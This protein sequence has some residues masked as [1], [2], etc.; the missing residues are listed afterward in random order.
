MGALFSRNSRSINEIYDDFKSGTLIIDTGYQRKKIWS[1]QDNVRFIETVLL[2]LVIP[3]VF[4]WIAETEPKTGKTITHIVD[5]QQRINAIVDFIDGQFILNKRFLLS[6]NMRIKHG[7]K[8]FTELGDESKIALWQY[9]FPIVELDRECTR[10]DIKNIFR[11]LNLTEYSL[12]PQ[13]RHHSEEDNCFGIA[14]EKLAENDFW[15]RMRVFSA[16]DCKRMKD[17]TYCCSIYILAKDGIIDQTDSRAVNEH[18]IDY[19]DKFDDD[20]AILNRIYSAMDIVEEFVD[21]DTLQFASK[22]A[23]LFS[24]MSLAFFMVDSRLSVTPANFSSFKLFVKA[25]SLFKNDY[26]ITLKNERQR[27]VYDE[28]RKYKLASSEG[29]NKGTNRT[30]RYKILYDLCIKPNSNY[31]TE[32]RAIIEELASCSASEKQDFTPINISTVPDLVDEIDS[33]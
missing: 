13:E 15:N 32:I 8:T 20:G 5:G 6:D 27:Y 18:Y 31:E 26:G 10:S 24:L 1:S 12:N 17:V 3:E 11:R 16:S 30:I 4:F 9:A 2:G 7:D 28:I 23:Q 14:C 25:Y 33:I 22:K 19:A 21:A 29:V